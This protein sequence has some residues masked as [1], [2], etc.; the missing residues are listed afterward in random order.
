MPTIRTATPDDLPALTDILNHYI[1]HT[2]INFDVEPYTVDARRAWF[3]EHGR[4]GKY[5][6]VVADDGGE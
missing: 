3:E 6:L 2:P 5:R 1:V 4:N